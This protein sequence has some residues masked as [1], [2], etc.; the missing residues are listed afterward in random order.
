VILNRCVTLLGSISLS[1]RWQCEGGGVGVDGALVVVRAC[2]ALTVTR[3]CA[4]NTTESSPRTATL[5][6]P[7]DLTALNAYSD[8]V[9]TGRGM[10][11]ASA[12]PS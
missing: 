1:C 2:R 5:V 7:V 11:H 6:R 3:F 10:N 4:K 12:P 9:A 8:K